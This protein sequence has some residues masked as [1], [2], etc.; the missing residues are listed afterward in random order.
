[1]SGD[2]EGDAGCKVAIEWDWVEGEQGGVYHKF[3]YD[4]EF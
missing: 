2:I 3:E 4:V 1:M